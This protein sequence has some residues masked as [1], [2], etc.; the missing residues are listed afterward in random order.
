[1]Y[2]RS[3]EI[4]GFKSFPEKTR[5]IFDK[6]ITAI[7]GPNGS[8][9]SNISD[10]ILWVMGE[11]STRTLRG[12]KMEDVIFGGTQRRSQVGF[13][14]VTL[15]LD[16]CDRLFD[17]DDSEVAITRRY[18][19]SGESE[20]YIN[21]QIVR[22]RDVNELL[23]DTGLG[24]EGYSIIG[25]GK[26][27]AILSAKSTDRRE[28]F[29][30]A[31]GISRFRHR[32]EESERKLEHTEENL[33]RL[34]DKISELSLQVEPLREQ[35]E[36]AR[37]YLIF[38]DELR[39]L[40]ISVWMDSLDHLQ[41]AVQKTAQ[42]QITAAEQKKN[43]ET[44]L[45]QFYE[46]AQTFS[47][48]MRDKDIEADGVRGKISESEAQSAE[49]DSAVAVLRSKLENNIG[50]TDRIKRELDEQEGRDGGIK[51]QIDERNARIADITNEKNELNE[52]SAAHLRELDALTDTAGEAAKKLGELIKSENETLTSIS[53]HKAKLSALASTAQEMYDRES[54]VALDS[55]AASDKLSQLEAE[56]AACDDELKKAKSEAESLKNMISGHTIRVDSRRKKAD[57][58]GDKKTK[59]TIE[60]NALKSRM[61]LLTEMERD[62]Q[63]YSKAVKLVMQ[64]AQR[65]IL[66][67]IHGT[68]AGLIKT[69]DKYTI[70]VETALGGAMQN[71]IVGTEED[72][73]EAI[74]MLK[75]RDGGRATF[76]PISTIRGN[77]INDKG[78]FTE[79]GFEGIALDLVRFDPKYEGVYMSLLGRVAIVEDMDDAIRISRKYK[80]SFRIVT[81]DGQV[82]NAG[83][84]MT[85]GSSGS[86]A[87]ILSRANELVQ[88]AEQEKIVAE[89]LLRAERELNEA[90]RE[91]NAAE[92]ELDV[93]NAEMRTAEDKILKLETNSNHYKLLLEAA[94]SSLEAL[95]AEASTLTERIVQNGRE[96]EEVRAAIADCESQAAT[97][98]SSIIAASEG[99]EQ[100]S[101]ERDR[102]TNS[103][104]ELRAREASCDAER[105]ALMKA[106]SELS[107]LREDL[108]GGRMQQL[109]FLEAL[110]VKNEEI[111]NDI[112]A[113]EI[114]LG[115]LAEKIEGYKAR[116][117]KI[118]EEK[119]EMEAERTRR[120]KMM[121]EKNRELI[122]LERECS[123]L[124]Q[125]KLAAEMEEKQI[126]DKL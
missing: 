124:E 24:R 62:Y 77:V 18:Y 60:Q 23:M 10:A 83:G 33:L 55:A 29:E 32:K 120:D 9:K 89:S 39:G 108:T 102:I 118:T 115:K 126:V 41:V 19:R 21:K 88:L 25:Q 121:Q 96:T 22:L 1:L 90:V 93:A 125:K 8:G 81:L 94:A 87:G 78:L 12:G 71:I 76:L 17:L 30:E 106:V 65:G 16:N 7:V 2:L 47:D 64:E 84:S 66:K 58:A 44:E 34:G 100:L 97:I 52:K 31:A 26:I 28:I 53:D 49:L 63:G 95:K 38:R 110:K 101:A 123:R 73:K 104:S 98:R 99:Q 75:R 54:T 79:E 59:V 42:D 122:E 68:V 70:A 111:L 46:G 82:I 57:A 20:Y 43:V 14:E 36:T 80:N 50:E 27:D 15:V 72:G 48:Q 4:Q 37:K 116:V 40:E 13:A 114:E 56:A 67:N 6:P 69:D 3:L 109:S 85:G 103:L 61:S 117:T 112:A 74:N 51:A 91:L 107:A 5:L 86:N 119:L 92:Y 35:A 11:Q 113:N 105:E 45:Q